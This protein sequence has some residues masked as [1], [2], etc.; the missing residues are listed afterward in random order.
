MT[1]N[2]VFLAYAAERYKNEKKMNGSELKTLFDKY[3]V[4]NYIYSSAPALHTTGDKYIIEDIDLFIE[5]KKIDVS[6]M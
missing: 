1:D 5:S 4:W 6:N 2:C 3:D